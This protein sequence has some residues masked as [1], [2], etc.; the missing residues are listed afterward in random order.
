MM[1]RLGLAV[2]ATLGL[3]FVSPLEA[4]DTDRP[5]GRAA[6][7]GS[8]S[9]S[10]TRAKTPAPSRTTQ[11]TDRGQESSKPHVFRRLGNS[12][13]R[14][15]GKT[16]A[17]LMPWS[18]PAKRGSHPVRTSRAGKSPKPKKKAFLSSWLK[19]KE[20]AAPPL[21]VDEFLAQPKPQ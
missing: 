18:K 15:F 13:K 16:K 4:K 19:P 2:V 10:L 21:T 6:R 1:K 11:A 12:T 14:F 5:R 3:W 17:V 8:L 20:T 9:E 7:A